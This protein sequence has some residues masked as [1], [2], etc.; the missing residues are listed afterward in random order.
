MLKA[1]NNMLKHDSEADRQACNFQTIA[2]GGLLDLK[3]FTVAT[4]LGHN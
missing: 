1:S 3:V 2:L 4:V